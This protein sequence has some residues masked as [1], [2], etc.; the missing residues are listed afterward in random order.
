MRIAIGAMLGGA[1]AAW[2]LSQFP[3]PDVNG[4]MVGGIIGYT[5]GTGCLLGGYIA[6]R[7]S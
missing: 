1:L 2:V 3:V 5:L 6:S 7:M 4:A